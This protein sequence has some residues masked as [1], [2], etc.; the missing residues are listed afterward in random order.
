MNL[1]MNLEMN[2][3]FLDSWRWAWRFL[4]MNLE[5]D[6][7]MN[8][9][10]GLEISWTLGDGLGVF[11]DSWRWEWCDPCARG[12][13]TVATGFHGAA[14]LRHAGGVPTRGAR[15]CGARARRRGRA[16]SGVGT[17]LTRQS[18]G[19]AD[20]LAR[21]LARARARSSRFNETRLH[22][23]HRNQSH[24]PTGETF[25]MTYLYKP[26]RVQMSVPRIA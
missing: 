9:E 2:V 8:L 17:M 16:A 14:R 13:N 6:L 4:G 26:K 18:T 1:E 5:L 15:A 11:L 20:L 23:Q 25:A 21:A 3:E 12:Q 7:E 22:K 10:M 24:N 19:G